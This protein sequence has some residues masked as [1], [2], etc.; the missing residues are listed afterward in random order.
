[1]QFSCMAASTS[2]ASSFSCLGLVVIRVSTRVP[3]SLLC[4]LPLAF[5]THMS[6]M[7]VPRPLRN[8]VHEFALLIIPLAS[9]P[10]RSATIAPS[11]WM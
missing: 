1:M 2:I 5:G 10:P 11:F 8:G 9:I 6:K 4:C 7:Y 3:C